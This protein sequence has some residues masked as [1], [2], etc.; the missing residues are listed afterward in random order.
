MRSWT[1]RA[2]ELAAVGAAARATLE[3]LAPQHLPAGAVLFRPGEAARGF[4]VVL[5]GRVEVHLT[6]PSGREI[7][8][9]AV[10][11][12][13]SCVQSTLAL[14]GGEDYTGEALSATETEAVLIPR[15]TFLRLVAEDA[16]FRGF[17]FS[18]FARRM[19]AMMLLLE[20]VAFLRVEA[21]LAAELL[22]LAGVGAVVRATHAELAARIG[23][24]REVVS[25]RLDALARSG[26]VTIA[27]GQVTITDRAAL[28]GRAAAAAG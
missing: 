13:Q 24:A 14:L 10:E 17:V 23:S 8:L 18:A 3:R 26:V 25:R 12:G 4:V 6:G 7:L 1:A 9:Y 22:A 15:E 5:S 27:R 11:P 28:A 16:G 19:Q 2:A 20:R 21:R